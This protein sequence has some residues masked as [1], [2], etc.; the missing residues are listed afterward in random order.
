MYP[1]EDIHRLGN[2]LRI[3]IDTEL[4][5]HQIQV[6]ILQYIQLILA[7][8]GINQLVL[9]DSR[10]FELLVNR[11]LLLIAFET[12]DGFGVGADGDVA[13]LFRVECGVFFGVADQVFED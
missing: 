3:L 9:P 1:L 7:G 13:L 8:E 5:H 12:Y 6:H 10:V 11:L 2:E 4:D